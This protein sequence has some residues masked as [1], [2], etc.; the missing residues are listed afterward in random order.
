MNRCRPHRAVFDYHTGGCNQNL[1]FLKKCGVI[2][3]NN[4]RALAGAHKES[5]MDAT[6][7]ATAIKRAAVQGKKLTPQEERVLRMRYG[8]G[9]KPGDDLGTIL[10]GAPEE[11]RAAV[12]AIEARALRHG[13]DEGV[14]SPAKLARMS[15][16]PGA[17]VG[18]GD[19][20][21]E[22]LHA[23]VKGHDEHLHRRG[24]GK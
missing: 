10:E 16:G 15:H 20:V 11:T 14:I 13:L 6:D 2:H 4:H 18:S 5:G 12:A 17:C 21:S 1:T 24:R 8:A 23:Q 9:V 19:A 3:H 22:V 7:M